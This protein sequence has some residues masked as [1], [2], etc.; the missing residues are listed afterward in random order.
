MSTIERKFE[1]VEVDS[2][3]RCQGVHKK[4]QC[5]YKATHPST[6]CPMHGANHAINAEQAKA[7]RM[8]NLGKWQQTVDDFADDDEVK[9]LRGEIGITRMMLQEMMLRC[10]DSG[11]LVMFSGKI[12]E[13]ISKIERL[14]VSCNRLETHL[15]LSLDKGKVLELGAQMVEIISRYITDEDVLS[16]IGDDIITLIAQSQGNPNKKD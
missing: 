1:I 8:Y 3:D 2:P 12:G 6:F 14:V 5:R 16:S 10:K 9:S 15:G 7:V 11:Q 4:G 13:L